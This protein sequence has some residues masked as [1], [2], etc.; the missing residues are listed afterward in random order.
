MKCCSSSAQ[1]HTTRS[2]KLR[3]E[4]A[5]AVAE[6]HEH[7]QELLGLFGIIVQTVHEEFEASLWAELTD[8]GP[9][10]GQKIIKVGET[11]RK[12]GDTATQC[13]LN[14]VRVRDSKSFNH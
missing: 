9:E 12:T 11:C 3:D 4:M 7:R 2:L 13:F 14:I 8:E 5:R 1:L 10:F 6:E